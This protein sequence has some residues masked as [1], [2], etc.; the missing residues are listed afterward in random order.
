MYAVCYRL[1]AAGNR[2]PTEQGDETTGFLA[3]RHGV[4]PVGYVRRKPFSVKPVEQLLFEIIA[5]FEKKYGSKLD[6][7]TD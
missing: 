4:P 5:V 6:A 1:Q 3:V 2:V 7:D